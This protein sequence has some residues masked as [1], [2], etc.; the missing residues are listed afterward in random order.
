MIE[1]QLVWM[2]GVFDGEGSI[3]I[4]RSKRQTTLVA[5][6]GNTE[7]E[8]VSPFKHRFGGT[9]WIERRPPDKTMFMWK[10]SARQA[11]AFLEEILPYLHSKRKRSIAVLAIEFQQIRKWGGGKSSH[12]PQLK[13]REERFRLAVRK[14]NDGRQRD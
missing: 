1:E 5:S 14:A 6:V 4:I 12:P 8:L 13:A 10:I 9:T 2:A 11:S 3:S 7:R